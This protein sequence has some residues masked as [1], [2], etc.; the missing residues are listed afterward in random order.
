MLFSAEKRGYFDESV[1]DLSL[2]AREGQA[3]A[4]SSSSSHR[5]YSICTP[6][7]IPHT[8]ALCNEVRSW[9]N[10]TNHNPI[11]NERLRD[12]VRGAHDVHPV[13]D[14]LK[15]G[16]RAPGARVPDKRLEVV[17]K[18]ESHLDRRD[19]EHRDRRADHDPADVRAAFKVAVAGYEED[20]QAVGDRDQDDSYVRVRVSDLG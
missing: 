11:A 8:S 13:R 10:G 9:A 12:I 19:R 20:A 2:Q 14:V 16:D 1:T 4:R 5:R 6:T 15:L 18:P 7:T 3:R 17:Q